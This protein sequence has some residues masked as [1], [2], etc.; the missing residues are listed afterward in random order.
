MSAPR[1]E[2]ETP[3]WAVTTSKP[4][5]NTKRYLKYICH[6]VWNVLVSMD[7]FQLAPNT[8]LPR[9]TERND[10]DTEVDLSLP[11]ARFPK[12][13]VVVPNYV[14]RSH[15]NGA[16]PSAPFDITPDSR[17]C[18]ETTLVDNRSECH[19]LDTNS[20]HLARFDDIHDCDVSPYSLSHLCSA[21]T[22][23]FSPTILSLSLPLHLASLN[24]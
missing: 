12:T 7:S 6:H 1:D 21:G 22:R 10:E 3:A 8:L 13:V 14:L 20:L 23:P 18:S 16:V 2:A 4:C 17:T 24:T 19:L 5:L 9:S 15:C 11:G